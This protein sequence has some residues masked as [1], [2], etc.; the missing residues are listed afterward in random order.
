MTGVGTLI[1][2]RCAGYVRVCFLTHHGEPMPE[3]LKRFGLATDYQLRQIERH[4]AIDVLT[5]LLHRDMAYGLELMP[6]TD[7]QR[8]A[9]WLL[10]RFPAEGSAF[11]TNGDWR[12]DSHGGSPGWTP[13]TASTFDGGVIATSGGLAACVWFEDE[14]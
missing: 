8:F 7:A 5:T 11:Y 2:R 3:T 13:L 10:E 1:T 9:V 12:R 6:A 4:R 14:D